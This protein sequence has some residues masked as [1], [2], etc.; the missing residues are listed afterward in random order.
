MEVQSDG[1]PQVRHQHA[2]LSLM[3]VNT[4]DLMAVGEDDERLEGVWGGGV[5]KYGTCKG[6][7]RGPGDCPC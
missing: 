2:E 1:V 7:F 4:T 5:E 3:E 6:S